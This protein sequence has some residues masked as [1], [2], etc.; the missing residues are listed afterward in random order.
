M[1]PGAYESCNGVDDDCDE[2][3]DEEVGSTWYRDDDGDGYGLDTDAVTTCSE[4][5]GYTSQGGDCRDDQSA[6][7]PG[8]YESCDGRDNDC[9][10][11]TDDYCNANL[12]AGAT[13]SAELVSGALLAAWLGIGAWRRRRQER[14]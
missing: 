3:V 11:K 7:N 9:N 6:V 4:P 8:A 12:H 13:P 14:A 5:A 1:H 10:G 2:L